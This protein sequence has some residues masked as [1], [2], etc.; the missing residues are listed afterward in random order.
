VRLQCS[1]YVACN[2]D[3]RGADDDD[4]GCSGKEK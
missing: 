4:G 3:E 2:Q 1:M